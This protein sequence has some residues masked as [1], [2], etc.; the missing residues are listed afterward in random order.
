MIIYSKEV[1]N[2]VNSTMKENEM[3][4]E[5]EKKIYIYKLHALN[6]WYA[7]LI[8]RHSVNDNVRIALT[9]YTRLA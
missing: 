2:T 9:L 6:F 5:E 1:V 7:W 8:G 3:A 4:V